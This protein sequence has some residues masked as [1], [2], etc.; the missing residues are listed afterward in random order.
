[1]SRSRVVVPLAFLTDLTI[2]Q[3]GVLK[4]LASF[5]LLL[6]VT[7]QV[8]FLS[9]PFPPAPS[10][11]VFRTIR[12]LK[13]LHEFGW[14]PIVLTVEH[15]ENFPIDETLKNKLPALQV[16][17]VPMPNSRILRTFHSTTSAGNE[18]ERAASA[19]QIVRRL[20]LPGKKLAKSIKGRY[21]DI[22][23][24]MIRWAKKAYS[25]GLGIIKE[26]DVQVLFSTAPPYSS[27]LLGCWLGRKTQ[28]P[29]VLDFRDPWSHSPWAHF[30]SDHVAKRNQQ[31]ERMCIETA[32]KVIANTDRAKQEFVDFYG[33]EQAEKFCTIY[34]GFDPDEL[35]N[36]Q[37]E[38]APT[39]SNRFTI[40][41]V[42][43]L[44]GHRDIRPFLKAIAEVNQKSNSIEICFEQIGHV[45]ADY[46]LVQFT[47]DLNIDRLVAFTPQLSHEEAL[48]KMA[49]SDALLLLQPEGRL[50]IP[51]KLFEMIL[52]RKPIL[53]LTGEGATRE[54]AAKYRLG[55]IADAADE[56]QLSNALLS[57]LG[58]TAIDQTDCEDVFHAFDGRNQT[59]ELARIFDSAE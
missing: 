56:E 17:R 25:K 3:D 43:K 41:H 38:K 59:R 30:R 1:M 50:Q 23:D 42:G 33:S 35:P 18:P 2:S 40:R 14:E 28:I 12:F 45:S 9:F 48:K 11:G 27:H 47:K 29:L 10:A 6:S 5:E 54:L 13:F 20:A 21:T 26:T 44:Y 36:F 34:N 49:S 53:T 52:F 51:G 32:H 8:L 24:A 15:D 16:H 37:V 31:M 19:K 57:A 58:E 39:D 7:K 22:P 4:H 55:P 46:D